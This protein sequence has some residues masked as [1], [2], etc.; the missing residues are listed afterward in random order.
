MLSPTSPPWPQ[1]PPPCHPQPIAFEAPSLKVAS[2]GSP[3]EV[4]HSLRSPSEPWLGAQCRSALPGSSGHPAG[5]RAPSQ[6][7]Q[8]LP[9]GELPTLYSTIR[10]S[11]RQVTQPLSASAVSSV[12]QEKQALPHSIVRVTFEDTGKAQSTLALTRCASMLATD[13]E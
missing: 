11:L 12:K 1:H 3:A 8:R 2:T 10:T 13:D 9:S 7:R 4:V 5:L 6:A